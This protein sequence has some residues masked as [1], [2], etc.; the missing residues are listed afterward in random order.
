[1][2]S[3]RVALFLGGLL[4]VGPA[5][6]AAVSGCSDEASAPGTTQTTGT[7]T[8][9]GGGGACGDEICDGWDNDCDGVGDE[10]CSCDAGDVQQ[11]YAADP[12]TA[13]V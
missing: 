1:M 6:L 5:Y 8:G 12:L 9:S 3:G 11:C 2:S 7:P 4:V 13:G 10:D